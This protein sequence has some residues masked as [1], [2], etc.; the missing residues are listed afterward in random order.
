LGLGICKGAWA[1]G[2]HLPY[3]ARRGAFGPSGPPERGRRPGRGAGEGGKV[4]MA[5]AGGGGGAGGG[6]EF[7]FSVSASS[8]CRVRTAGYATQGTHKLV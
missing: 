3:C 7:F 1:R 6:G 5:A 8:C 2:R 4:V